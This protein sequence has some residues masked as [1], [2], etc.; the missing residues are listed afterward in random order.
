MSLYLHERLI[1]LLLLFP[2]EKGGGEG[3]GGEEGRGQAACYIWERECLHPTH[4]LFLD[5]PVCRRVRVLVCVGVFAL[6]CVQK[7][8]VEVRVCDSVFTSVCL[9]T[10]MRLCVCLCMGA[11]A[12]VSVW[13]SQVLA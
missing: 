1:L 5:N 7:S 11:R 8:E 3:G 12:C 6:L 9:C 10:S 13:L 4:T 2:L